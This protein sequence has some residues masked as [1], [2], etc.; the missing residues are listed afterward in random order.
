MDIYNKQN[1]DILNLDE[2]TR[3][4]TI[5]SS[6]KSRFQEISFSAHM[7]FSQSI[8]KQS[9][10][11]CENKNEEDSSQRFQEIAS[12]EKSINQK[13]ESSLINMQIFDEIQQENFYLKRI[14]KLK[15]NKIKLLNDK[16]A[17]FQNEINTLKKENEKNRKQIKNIELELFQSKEI[18]QIEIKHNEKYF[19]ENHLDDC[20]NDSLI[21]NESDA[22][23]LSKDKILGSSLKNE[24]NT[25]NFDEFKLNLFWD[26][27]NVA[28]FNLESN[29]LE[30]K[31]EL[32]PGEGDK[33]QDLENIQF[34]LKTMKQSN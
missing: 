22:I 19:K 13:D 21:K 9:S 5:F 32:D 1:Q 31:I 2:K 28:K 20:F 7:D 17:S 14:L 34:S 30:M 27:Q 4:K 6:I 16:L 10:P 15:Q 11:L 24:P 33:S 25:I 23:L 26:M 3:K 18:K 29:I 8:M 12:K